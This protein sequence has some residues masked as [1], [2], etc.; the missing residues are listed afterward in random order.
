MWVIPQ[1][2]KDSELNIYVSVRNVNP[3]V[4]MTN[5]HAAFW[6]YSVTDGGVL[7]GDGYSVTHSP[8]ASTNCANPALLCGVVAQPLLYYSEYG[9]VQKYGQHDAVALSGGAS[10]VPYISYV[11]SVT[12]WT[13]SKFTNLVLKPCLGAFRTN[14]TGAVANY[15]YFGFM[16]PALNY[17]NVSSSVGGTTAITAT[18]ETVTVS[19]YPNYPGGYCIPLGNVAATASSASGTTIKAFVRCLG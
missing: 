12:S 19:A 1:F 8:I 13:Q 2:G 11:G 10:G 4:K 6:Y 15:G 9:L 14:S 5:G 18:A 7:Y 3:S 16:A 17:F